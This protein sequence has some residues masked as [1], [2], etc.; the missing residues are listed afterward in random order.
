[1]PKHTRSVAVKTKS[2]LR[3]DWQGDTDKVT[4]PDCGQQP[5][6]VVGVAPARVRGT[7]SRAA[8]LDQGAVNMTIPPDTSSPRS[9]PTP[10]HAG[11]TTTSNRSAR[12]VA[13]FVATTLVLTVILS[14]WR[15][16]HEERSPSTV[17]IGAALEAP[18]DEAPPPPEPAEHR[19][20]Q[21]PRKY[22]KTV[23][24]VP[25]SY[26]VPAS[27]WVQFGSISLN[28]SETGP[29][30]AEAM[31]YWSG[32]PG[33]GYLDPSGRY[34]HPCVRLLSPPVGPSTADLAT[35]ITTAPGVQLLAGPSDDRV[36][37]YPA[38]RLMLA[39][40]DR[41][42][43]DPGVFY[44]WQDELGGPLLPR[45]PVGSTLRVWILRVAGMRLFIGAVTTPQASP[46][47][48]QEVERI[49]QSI[50]FR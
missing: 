37:G 47:L 40:R 18:V 7:D 27:G 22:V 8:G 46:D 41:S 39:V 30:G 31:I 5:L 36:G 20:L 50:H 48:E 10:A 44:Y 42:L 9:D 19:V 32:F 25:F 2:C 15:N 3:C 23:D 49:I 11:T 12:T 6:Y 38:R 21:G 34:A 29:Q 45:T 43:C 14:T 35:A 24:A 13:A 16:P 1:M 33:G 26:R 17:T 28:K 4:C